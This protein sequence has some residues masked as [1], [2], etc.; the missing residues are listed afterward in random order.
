MGRQGKEHTLGDGI[1]IS[2][3]DDCFVKNGNKVKLSG[4]ARLVSDKKNPGF[5]IT[6]VPADFFDKLGD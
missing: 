3:G 2:I 1:K 6:Y 4:K 5:G